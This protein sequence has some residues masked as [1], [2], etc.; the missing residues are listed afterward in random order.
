LRNNSK[1]KKILILAN[2]SLFFRQH[3]YG[4]FQ[5]VDY[6]TQVYFV[7]KK[8]DYFKL[9][10][11]RIKYLPI[12]I[13]RNPSPID[14]FTL[15]SYSIIRL[16]IK[17]DI[18]LSFTPKASLI[19]AL[20]AFFPGKT[21]H[22]FTGQRWTNFRGLKLFLFKLIDYFVIKISNKTYSDSFSQSKFISKQLNVIKPK[23]IH[24]GSLSG[25]DLK[26]YTP[27]KIFLKNKISSDS[28]INLIKFKKL[29][30]EA[31]SNKDILIFGFVGRINLDKGIDLLIKAFQKH[32]RRFISN[33][34]IILGPLEI[35]KDYFKALINNNKNILH[36]NYT[37]QPQ[38]FYPEFDMLLLPSLREGFGS[39]II[40]AAACKVPTIST[41]I[42][43]PID[44]I[45]HKQ[46]GY[47]IKKSSINS[48]L[49][50]LN[51]FASNKYLISKMGENAYDLVL[52]KYSRKSISKKF[53]NEFGIY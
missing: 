22:Y 30:I 50:S 18:S 9:K 42:P 34:L 11:K 28:N 24:Y 36:I 6:N 49:K 20:T 27:K 16:K 15:I 38:N 5:E 45:K 8:D 26:K 39:V 53:T 12:L 33:K 43:G 10:S 52:K 32:N 40:E 25:V 23:V 19:N 46:N 7:T 31:K 13:H 47:F 3:L 29:I 14:L 1:L 44:F 48:I 51:F 17:P 35:D 41:K 4:L 21:I 37:D 2:S